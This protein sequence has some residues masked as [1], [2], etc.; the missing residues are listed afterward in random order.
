MSTVVGYMVVRRTPEGYVNSWLGT[1][2]VSTNRTHIQTK[3]DNYNNWF[4]EPMFKI[5]TIT[6]EPDEGFCECGH[7][8]NI[9]YHLEGCSN[10]DCDCAQHEYCR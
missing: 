10:K 8:K 3:V 9:H 2:E 6:V 5:A 7:A 4:D 1:T